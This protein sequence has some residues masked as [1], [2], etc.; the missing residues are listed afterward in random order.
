MAHE[1]TPVRRRSPRLIAFTF[2]A[3]FGASVFTV[4]YTGLRV[5]APRTEISAALPLIAMTVNQAR[6]VNFVFASSVDVADATLTIDLPSGVELL[7]Y[8]GERQVSWTTGLQAGNNILP[9]TLIARTPATGQITA[10]LRYE[11]RDKVFR[12]LVDALAE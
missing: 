10:R 8:A 6:T 12:V 5:G 11:E 7:D 4:I 2:V 9:L 1:S 3:A